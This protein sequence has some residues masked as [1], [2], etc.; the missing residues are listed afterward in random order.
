MRII[1]GYAYLGTAYPDP[2]IS[3]LKYAYL[4]TTYPYPGCSNMRIPD[5]GTVIPYNLDE[6]ERKAGKGGVRGKE[7]RDV[8]GS[9]I[10]NRSVCI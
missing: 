7:W 8:D 10:W 4:D 5:T 6:C 1:R 9:W 3:S 2:I